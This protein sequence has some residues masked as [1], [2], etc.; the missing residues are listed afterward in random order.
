MIRDETHRLR[1]VTYHR[2]R[3]EVARTLP[4]ELSAISRRGRE[5]ER[6]AC[7]PSLRIDSQD[8][9]S[10]RGNNWA[11]RSSG[12]KNGPGEIV[13]HFAKQRALGGKRRC[14]D[15]DYFLLTIKLNWALGVSLQLLLQELP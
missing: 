1:A 8:F 14:E 15:V 10:D 6:R 13:Y 3:R 9:G 2:K 4:S 7:L 11:A 5:T 12:E